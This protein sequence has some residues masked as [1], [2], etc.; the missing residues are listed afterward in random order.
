MGLKPGTP[1]AN[2]GEE[3][4]EASEQE[5]YTTED[6]SE[7]EEDSGEETETDPGSPTSPRDRRKHSKEKMDGSPNNNNA[8]GL[9]KT[10]SSKLGNSGKNKSS[11][12]KNSM[13]STNTANTS[14][15][16]DEKSAISMIVDGVHTAPNPWSNRLDYGITS[17][18]A[19]GQKCNE[20]YFCGV[21]D[22]LQQ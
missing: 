22:I 9:K 3:E 21:I 8:G 15:E 4:V 20:I 12:R 5:D 14:V 18:D 19:N 13:L 10:L 6:E 16:D 11:G 17:V 2:I 1:L 7:F